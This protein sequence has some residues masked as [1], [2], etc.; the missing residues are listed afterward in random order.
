[1]KKKKS[2]NVQLWKEFH[3]QFLHMMISALNS[4]YQ[5]HPTHTQNIYFSM[6]FA[7]AHGLSSTL[8]RGHNNQNLKLHLPLGVG[9]PPPLMAQFPDI[10]LPHFFFAIE[11][12]TYKTDFT[13]GLSQK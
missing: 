2:R 3:C 4:H 6:I 10:F 11:S 12:Y 1:M 7:F 9:P 5:T 8:K 13:L